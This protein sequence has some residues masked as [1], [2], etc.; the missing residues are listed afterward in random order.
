MTAFRYL[1]YAVELV[2]IRHG[3]GVVRARLT[4][5]NDEASDGRE[6]PVPDLDDV[7][8]SRHRKAAGHRVRTKLETG[9]GEVQRT[10]QPCSMHNNMGPRLRD[11]TYRG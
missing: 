10:L 11:Y 3:D 2:S 8:P 5:S 4:V 7:G 1:V 6:V 9:E